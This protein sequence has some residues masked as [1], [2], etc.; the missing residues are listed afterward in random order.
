MIARRRYLAFALLAAMLASLPV[1]AAAPARKGRPL[2]ADAGDS[3]FLPV[4]DPHVLG[5]MAWGG[6]TPYRYTWSFK[7]SAK[8][9]SHPGGPNTTFDTLGL[10][11]GDYDLELTVRDAA[12]ATARDGV[13][14]RLFNQKPVPIFEH[15]DSIG[16]GI[17]DEDLFGHEPGSGIDGQTKAHEF[18]VPAGLRRL[19]IEL[20]W[21]GYI[22]PADGLFT[23][24]IVGV[25]DLDLYVEGPDPA[26][27]ELTSGASPGNMPEVVAIDD[28][29]PGAYR[30]I[31]SGYLNIPD[32]YK[33]TVSVLSAPS[34]NPMPTIEVPATMRFVAGE[35]HSIKAKV[36]GTRD[37][38]WDLNFDGVF[39]QKGTSITGRVPRGTWLV[40]VKATRGGFELRRTIG[41]TVASAD[42]IANNTTPFVI[43]GMGDSG[44]NPYHEEFSA[45]TYPDPEVLRITRNFTRHPSEYIP[46]YPKNTPALPVTLGKDYLP[47]EDEELWTRD[48]IEFQKLYWIPG[49]KIVGAI[50]WTDSSGLNAAD[51]I[52]PI[53]D[54]DGHGTQSAGTAVGNRF[55]Y[56]PACLIVFAEG[57]QGDEFLIQ[58]PWIDI[59]SMSV[60]TAGNIGFGIID[61]DAS[62]VAAE[63][64]Q[65][66]IFAA[67][68]GFGNAF[69][70]PMSTY[71]SAS[72]GPD[73]HV[74]VGAARTDNR[75]PIFG[76]ANP[77]DISS[78]GDG[79]VPT[80]CVSGTVGM[81]NHGG[82][83]SAT[84][85]TSGVF[86]QVLREV[87][88][89]VGDTSMGQRPGQVVAK[90][91]PVTASAFLRDG[92]LTRAELWDIVFHTAEPFGASGVPI[93]PYT[94]TW[95]G[96]DSTDYIAGGY[97]LAT[98]KSAVQAI[99]V[100]LGKAPK[101]ERPAEDS[102]P[103]RRSAARCGATGTTAPKPRRRVAPPPRSGC[104]SSE[105]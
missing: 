33:V 99:D 77:V 24:P 85:L 66:V 30:A 4:G 57:L 7:G 2:I 83:S 101:P 25:Q 82:T 21:A 97:G 53:L 28:P 27:A 12:G 65:T 39:E 76:D 47:P 42:E 9:F 48:R 62:K 29:K 1:G 16:V 40:T 96:P 100:A 18:T 61:S 38:R 22:D 55:G 10:K 19:E 31:V 35:K 70:V 3:A 56:C 11:A 26:Y 79:T 71:T 8:R 52:A 102:Q 86:G 63:R 49:S 60:G 34:N 64:G 69:D 94:F 13:K 105:T 67:G 17:P 104:S 6:K 89:A 45:K 32:T 91:A 78:W 46:G 43:I 58:Q 51:D 73:W 54:E 90:G 98:P 44:I 14:I 74:V 84:P 103:T 36:A 75:R 88:R 59:V 93:P 81:C 5:G 87:R 68:N 92:A 15:E 72:A 41:V 95:P 50:D 20:S 37:V 23:P 80:A